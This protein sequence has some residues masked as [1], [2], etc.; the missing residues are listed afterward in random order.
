MNILLAQTTIRLLLSHNFSV[1]GNTGGQ[2]AEW[3]F[4]YVSV[5]VFIR[6]IEKKRETERRDPYPRREECRI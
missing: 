3:E 2:K 4:V 5:V 1:V 6:E